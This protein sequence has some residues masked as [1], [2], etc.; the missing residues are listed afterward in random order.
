M[1][2]SDDQPNPPSS[3]SS[4][5]SPKVDFRQ[6]HQLQPDATD[7]ELML[8]DRRLAEA[9]AQLK[10]RRDAHHWAFL[11]SKSFWYAIFGFL[12]FVYI[13]ILLVWGMK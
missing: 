5:S 3:P 1:S 12:F 10:E 4:P 8:K 11:Q 7:R 9:L 2:N 13:F 6:Y